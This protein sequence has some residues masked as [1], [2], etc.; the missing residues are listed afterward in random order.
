MKMIGIVG[1]MGPIAGLDLSKKIVNQ[2]IA[3]NDQDHIS[4][5]LYSSPKQIT[6]R[7][8]YLLGKINENPAYAI[9]EILIHLEE[10]GA[11]V[12]GIPCN[13]A[14]VP[15]IFEVVEQQ[16]REK[17]ASIKL[18]HLIDEVGRFIAKHFPKLKKVGVLGTLGTFKLGLYDSLENFGMKIINLSEEEAAN[19][20]Q[21]V[22]DSD[23]GL[24]SVTDEISGQAMNILDS[25]CQSLIKKGAQVIVLG[26]TELPLAFPYPHYNHIPL[27]D[28]TMVLARAL[29]SDV[30]ETKLKKI[31]L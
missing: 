20:H 1:G 12:A 6:D 8:D 25:A 22:Y 7:T 27:V 19:V 15:Q 13:T 26:C 29:I 3:S 11:T 4:Q 30:D 10:M 14:H 2:T 23:F 16:L 9:T 31:E 28:T 18:I 5:I 17:N 24:K 21:A